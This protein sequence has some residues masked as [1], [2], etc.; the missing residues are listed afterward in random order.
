MSTVLVTGA[1]RGL[2]LEFSRQYAADG[3]HVL[4]GCRSPGKAQALQ[5]LMHDPKGKL[6]LIEVEVADSGSVRRAPP[7]SASRPSTC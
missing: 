5:R 3:W 4:A 2:G 6:D 1:N 7:R